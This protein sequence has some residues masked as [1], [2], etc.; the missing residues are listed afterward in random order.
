MKRGFA[1]LIVLQSM[2]GCS[3]AFSTIGSWTVEAPPPATITTNHLVALADG[4]VALFG[5]YT[6]QTGQAS[7]KVL[8]FDPAT[9]RWTNGAPLPGPAYPDF[10]VQLPDGTVLVEGGYDPATGALSGA[11]WIYDPARNSWSQA[12]SLAPAQS[13]PSYAVLSD[14]RVLIAGGGVPLTEPET[15]PNGTIV[16]FE[17][18]TIAEIFDP[19]TKVWSPA[20]HL[21]VARSG[22]SLVALSGGGALA[23]GGC[24]GAAGWTPPVATS[25]VF[26]PVTYTWS[27]TTPTPIPMCGS[28]NAALRDGRALVVDQFTFGTVE[29]YFFNPSENAFVYDP[30]TRQWSVTGALAGGGTSALTLSDGRVMVPETQAGQVQGHT[31]EEMVGGQIFDPATNQWAFASTT[32]VTLP[33]LYLYNGGG[34]E[35]A[36]S[37]PNGSALVF[38]P[39]A[40]LAF[41]PQVAPPPTQV[42]DSTGLTLLLL[43]AAAVIAILML[44]AYRRAGRVDLNK[45]A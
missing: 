23:A 41:H 3:F 13:G 4:R 28:T 17:P 25:E 42:L 32:S 11:T 30:K 5:D 36:V 7:P 34:T 16:N 9:G 10:A 43:A 12:G 6:L 19:N 15:L 37:L 31:F 27:L 14:G 8:L 29:R 44:V 21:Q 45:L 24:Q 40:T 2:S 18:T 20:G 39:T 22:I 26:D 1:L 38:L 33:V 35:L